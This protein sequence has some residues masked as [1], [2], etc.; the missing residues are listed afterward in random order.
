MHEKMTFSERIA[1]VV[2][3]AGQRPKQYWNGYWYTWNAK[4]GDYTRG[5]KEGNRTVVK[6][7]SEDKKEALSKL[8]EQ[9]QL[10]SLPTDPYDLLSWGEKKSDS[11]SEPK[12]E[13]TTE[14]KQE[15]PK[16]K[17]KE[18]EPKKSDPLDKIYGNSK[19]WSSKGGLVI[20]CE[21]EDGTRLTVIPTIFLG[22]ADDENIIPNLEL[23]G[24]IL[25]DEG[26][27]LVRDGGV[28]QDGFKELVKLGVID[29]DN[30]TFE[31]GR[32]PVNIDKDQHIFLRENNVLENDLPEF[33]EKT[34]K[35]EPEP[36]EEPQPEH[37]P[38]PE[39]EPEPKEEPQTEPEIEEPKE[40]P[41]SAEEPETDTEE[42][43]KEEEQI[44]EE[45]EEDEE[46]DEES[47]EYSLEQYEY[48][49]RGFC[50]QGDDVV[51][52]GLVQ[53]VPRLAQ[54]DRKIFEA[55]LAFGGA[56]TLPKLRKGIRRFKKLIAEGRVGCLRKEEED[57]LK[58]VFN[59]GDK[60]PDG[61]EVQ[62][63]AA[64]IATT[65]VNL[66]AQHRFV[67]KV[68]PEEAAIISKEKQESEDAEEE[69]SAEPESESEKPLA[70]MTGSSAPEQE[71]TEEVYTAKELRQKLLTSNDLS[72]DD[73]DR[74]IQSWANSFFN[75]GLPFEKKIVDFFNSDTLPVHA[76][77]GAFTEMLKYGSVDEVIGS[78]RTLKEALELGDRDQLDSF[79]RAINR[80]IDDGVKNVESEW[81]GSYGLAHCFRATYTVWP[82]NEKNYDVLQ[83][84]SNPRALHPFYSR[85]KG[86]AK[87][88]SLVRIPSYVSKEDRKKIVENVVYV[89]NVASLPTTTDYEAFMLVSAINN[90]NVMTNKEKG[91]ITA[92]TFKK[93]LRDYLPKR[94]IDEIVSR[95]PEGAPKP[96]KDEPVSKEEPQE[97]EPRRPVDLTIHSADSSDDFL[98]IVEEV[99]NSTMTPE[100]AERDRE[101]NRQMVE[102]Y[103]EAAQ[104]FADHS[105][106]YDELEKAQARAWNR[107][108]NLNKKRFDWIFNQKGTN[109]SFQSKEA[110]EEASNEHSR[111]T[112][113]LRELGAE[114]L[115]HVRK[116]KEE[117]EQMSRDRAKKIAFLKAAF[118]DRGGASFFTNE[119]K[120]TAVRVLSAHDKELASAMEEAIEIYDI[121][122]RCYNTSGA[123]FNPPVIK[124]G[125]TESDTGAYF[126]YGDNTVVISNSRDKDRTKNM[127]LMFVAHELGHW[128]EM[129][130]L[131]LNAAGDN[132]R[133][134]ARELSVPN[135]E[136]MSYKKLMKRAPDLTVRY[137]GYGLHTYKSAYAASRGHSEVISTA[138]EY[139]VAAPVM[140]ATR[141]P[142]Q[143]NLL[144]R[145]FD[146]FTTSEKLASV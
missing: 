59:L 146:K 28:T 7:L 112:K 66:Y 3:Y 80:V 84:K 145:N 115:K 27:L 57:E 139:L 5:F 110:L 65:M 64:A 122:G 72:V 142:K 51:T 23:A 105:E 81:S 15:E 89:Q 74:M 12:K 18:E 60:V 85:E 140:F 25:D 20:D 136:Y 137:D 8:A 48:D 123:K 29:G 125:K 98:S 111:L 69:S 71:K 103:H 119:W 4:A 26:M 106:E 83:M 141:S 14:P 73:A 107:Y 40:E 19:V 101:S 135:P 104:Y 67:A 99:R 68:T 108:K 16:P 35:K 134:L 126:S 97:E 76:K 43:P 36:K 41:E 21:A 90:A 79:T 130:G 75:S 102:T 117:V 100:E 53:S 38:Q 143:F 88:R 128:L 42:E 144:L 77:E 54:L 31:N 114:L 95:V 32:N 9:G 46:E 78:T 11:S 129:R 87:I 91:Y 82:S 70:P 116:A 24:F 50:K 124:F 45:H 30:H 61:L 52:L 127:I 2:Q 6:T 118:P 120:E 22:D 1:K 10:D 33:A 63:Y 113:Q 55:A 121:I 92:E 37:E 58:L 96:P 44:E 39:P 62:K 138:M 47:Q 13:P 131:G 133:F 132:T 56:D 17:P 94:A 93:H 86:V 109:D 34:E 49:D